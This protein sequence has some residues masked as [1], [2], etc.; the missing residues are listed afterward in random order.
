MSYIYIDN[1]LSE[2][3]HALLIKEL[4]KITFKTNPAGCS[5]TLL[6][7]NNDTICKMLVKCIDSNTQFDEITA[8]KYTSG[9]Y[10][11]SH[12]DSP[13]IVGN[14]VVLSLNTPA[15]MILDGLEIKLLPR[16][17]IEFDKTLEHSIKPV[18]GLRYSIVMRKFGSELCF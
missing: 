14:V 10:I 18:D 12:R 5:T 2:E 3:L 6:S 11:K 16:S 4:D 8:N 9:E 7:Q 17:R 1:Y 13:A 15:T